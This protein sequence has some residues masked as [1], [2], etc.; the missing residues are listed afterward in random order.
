MD[1]HDKGRFILKSD[2]NY[3]QTFRF[4]VLKSDKQLRPDFWFSGTS[5]IMYVLKETGEIK[6]HKIQNPF[7]SFQT[8]ADNDE[9]ECF[10]ME[11]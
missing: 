1:T 7:L 10:C 8:L 11:V 5:E 6:L 3:E 2:N 4:S 9:I